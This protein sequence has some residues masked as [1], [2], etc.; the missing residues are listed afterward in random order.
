MASTSFAALTAE[1]E[2]ARTPAFP[3]RPGSGPVE[4]VSILI[5]ALG[6]AGS[7]RVWQRE[8]RAG[9]ASGIAGLLLGFVVETTPH[10]VHHSLDADQGAG[11]E[12]LQTAERNQAVVVAPDTIP[13]TT[14]ASLDEPPSL[15]SSPTP[16]AP[17]PC[18]RAPPA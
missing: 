3:G 17:A 1:A 15:V 6:L 13:V 10:L 9:L 8:R 7:W 4:A 16:F 2:L 18:G 12:A 11:C 14:P 5:V